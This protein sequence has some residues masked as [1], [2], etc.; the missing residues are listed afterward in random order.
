MLSGV[1]GMGPKLSSH[2]ARISPTLGALS[3]PSLVVVDTVRAGSC[4]RLQRCAETIIGATA[5]ESNWTM[6]GVQGAMGAHAQPYLLLNAKSYS[7]AP[8][9]LV[10]SAPE[11]HRVTSPPS[12]LPRAECGVA[13]AIMCRLRGCNGSGVSLL[14]RVCAFSPVAVP[15]MGSESS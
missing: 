3:H 7:K 10:F 6:P 11:V 5:V 8:Y 9:G 15:N 14:F 4:R 1:A 2:P 13:P 12:C